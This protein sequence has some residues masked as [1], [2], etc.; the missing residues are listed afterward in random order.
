VYAHL[1]ANGGCDGSDVEVSMGV[2][3]ATACGMYGFNRVSAT[4]MG[5]QAQPS[6]LTLV[7]THVSPKIWKDSTALLEVLPSQQNAAL[8]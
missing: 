1:I 8:R 2:Y 3:S 5:S 6:T 7:S 4:E